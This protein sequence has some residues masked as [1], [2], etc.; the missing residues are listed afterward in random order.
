MY[1]AAPC[2]TI[3]CA[4]SMHSSRLVIQLRSWKDHARRYNKRYRIL[5]LGSF[6]HSQLYPALIVRKIA[7]PHHHLICSDVP[8]MPS[9]SCR[10][11]SQTSHMSNF[12]VSSI[13]GQDAVQDSYPKNSSLTIRVS[14]KADCRSE[15]E[16]CPVIATGYMADWLRLN[17]SSDHDT[18]VSIWSLVKNTTGLRTLRRVSIC[19]DVNIVTCVVKSNFNSSRAEI[20]AVNRAMRRSIAGRWPVNV[21][22]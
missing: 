20:F 12:T 11:A 13:E 1:N 22:R 15:S 2:P 8:I 6:T 18:S 17:I 10:K 3:Y 14:K 7:V 5:V 16:P 21:S 4:K 19:W 9:S